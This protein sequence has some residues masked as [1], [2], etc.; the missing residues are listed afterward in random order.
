MPARWGTA[1]T[2]P[3]LP[4]TCGHIRGHAHPCHSLQNLS[5]THTRAFHRQPALSHAH[6]QCSLW[7]SEGTQAYV[8][9]RRR[10]T[11]AGAHT[12]L[13]KLMAAVRVTANLDFH[14]ET[15]P[16]GR[17]S[18]KTEHFGETRCTPPSFPHVPRMQTCPGTCSHT[19]LIDLDRQVPAPEPRGH[20]L[21]LDQLPSPPNHVHTRA[22]PCTHTGI[23][24]QP[25]Y[26]SL[27]V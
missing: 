26:S 20:R 17:F 19:L 14:Q 15:E 1:D 7:G 27:L 21:L 5:H 22:R 25:F 10:G 12:H 4:A 24:P 16:R 2:H 23:R 8:D 9:T 13:A 18:P 6:S 11:R 3:R